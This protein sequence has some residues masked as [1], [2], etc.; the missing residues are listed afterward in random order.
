MTKTTK[1]YLWGIVGFIVVLIGAQMWSSSAASV[2]P[3]ASGE[4][5]FSET[6]WDFGD[7][8]MADGIV[9]Q[10][11]P[12]ENETQAPITITRLETSCMCT[13]AQVVH[14][15]GSKS[16]LK[17]MVGHGGT[18]SVSET[19]EPG[20]TAT[21]LVNFDPNAHGPSATGAIR[22]TVSLQTNSQTQSDVELTFSGMV[23]K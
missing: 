3:I 12:V 17:G 23:T 16:G 19:I 4:L 6:D 5:T 20:E 13:T 15:D 18:P 11:I 8:S 9:T 14:E 1:Y 7:I 10:S 22:R 21:L 2:E